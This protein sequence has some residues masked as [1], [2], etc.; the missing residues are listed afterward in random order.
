MKLLIQERYFGDVH[1]VWCSE[2]FDPS[3]SDQHY[4]LSQVPASSNPREIGKALALAVLS[5]DQ[6]N[7]HIKRVRAFYVSHARKLRK[8]GVLTDQEYDDLVFQVKSQN[9]RLWRPICY[10]IARPSVEPRLILVRARVS[11]GFGKEYKIA[12]LKRDEFETMELS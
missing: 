11:A 6:H 12:D 7:D 9:F 1:Y 10:V 4:E 3:S 5:G 8:S 2:T